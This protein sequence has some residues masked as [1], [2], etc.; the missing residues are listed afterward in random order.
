MSG[1]TCGAMPANKALNLTGAD[2]ALM[3]A[4]TGPFGPAAR[5]IATGADCRVVALRPQVNASTLARRH[6]T[7]R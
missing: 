6:R 7:C 4:A 1:V 3:S 2:G 5:A